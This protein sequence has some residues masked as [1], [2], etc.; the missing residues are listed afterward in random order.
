MVNN[1]EG[2]KID[3]VYG[4]EVDILETDHI[5]SMKKIVMMEGFTKLTFEQQLEILN[6]KENFMGLGKQM[7]QKGK[8]VGQNGKDILN[9]EKY[10][11][12]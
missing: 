8:R 11:M 2:K 6:L 5:V 3:P 12:M 7:L 1:V 10:Q 9:L 4:Y